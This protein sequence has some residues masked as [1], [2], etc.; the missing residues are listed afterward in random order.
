MSVPFQA[1][2]VSDVTSH[3]PRYLPVP[4]HCSPAGNSR[5]KSFPSGYL[6]L[7][8]RERIDFAGQAVDVAGS[9][10]D[11][12]GGSPVPAWRRDQRGLWARDRCPEALACSPNAVR[13]RAGRWTVTVRPPPR[14][15][16]AVTVPP[17]AVAV[18]RTID[19]P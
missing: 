12:T 8:Q 13:S 5:F 7:V 17:W 15:G 4:R 9:D 14:R 2:T 19:R 1:M 10:R 6:D 3:W 16:A 11:R 18:A